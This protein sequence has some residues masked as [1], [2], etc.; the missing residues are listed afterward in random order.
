[1]GRRGAKVLTLIRLLA[2]I[3]SESHRM[4]ARKWPEVPPELE[5]DEAASWAHREN[6]RVKREIEAEQAQLAGA[7]KLA[8]IFSAAVSVALILATVAVW[9]YFVAVGA[10]IATN[11]QGLDPFTLA[12]IIRD[13]AAA[14]GSAALWGSLAIFAL[15]GVDLAGWTLADAPETPKT[16]PEPWAIRVKRIKRRLSKLN[17]WRKK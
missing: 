2:A 3:R 15:V 12:D 10:D 16:Q 5:G 11:V 9:R 14:W 1:M 4:A 7:V 13:R 6:E 17:P 8:W